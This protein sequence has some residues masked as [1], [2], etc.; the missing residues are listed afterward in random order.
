MWKWQC[1]KRKGG[2][3]GQQILFP[4]NFSTGPPLIASFFPLLFLFH[5]LAPYAAGIAHDSLHCEKDE[6]TGE[7]K[8]EE[9]SHHIL[10]LIERDDEIAKQYAEEHGMLIK[11]SD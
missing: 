9:P 5:F 1:S 10:K 3:Q 6:K 2:R 4:T 11:V 7:P 8:C